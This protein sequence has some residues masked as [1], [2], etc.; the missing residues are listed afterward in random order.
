METVPVFDNMRAVLVCACL[1]FLALA[2]VGCGGGGG[3][4]PTPSPGP[5]PAPGPPAPPP[6][7]AQ[8]DVALLSYNLEW[9]KT[10]GNQDVIKTINGV[11]PFD[12][13]G[14]QECDDIS[15]FINDVAPGEKTY[16]T[17]Q[18][19]ADIAIAW[20]TKIFK[21]VSEGDA[22]AGSDG[23]GPR[24]LHWVRLNIIGSDKHILMANTHG[25]VN[26]CSGKYESWK[27]VAHNYVSNIE[28]AMKPGD[29]MFFTGDFNCGSTPTDGHNPH[30]AGLDAIIT[31]IRKSF[32]DIG[33]ASFFYP[34]L[35]QPD[36]IYTMKDSDTVTVDWAAMCCDTPG[37]C[38]K[39]E[40]KKDDP[41][42]PTAA[43]CVAYPSDHMLLKANFKVP[44]GS[45]KL[46]V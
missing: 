21:K 5:T 40:Q 23:W 7:P 41:D 1:A 13:M 26:Q 42:D 36:R 8:L 18:G 22:I 2:L 20:N 15:V 38:K 45:K 27:E 39:V 43:R 25:P 14:F 33:A 16:E 24:H 12:L 46:I 19:P 11:G 30:G 37:S 9:H 28:G 6:A 31:E 44:T 17:K 34:A 29:H 32:T 3:G 4:D 10:M 35:Y